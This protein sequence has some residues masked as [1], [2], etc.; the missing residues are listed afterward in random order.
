MY[1]SE[2]FDYKI[3]PDG[4]DTDEFYLKYKMLDLMF[5]G[6]EMRSNAAYLTDLIEKSYF[7]DGDLGNWESMV[8]GLADVIY[9]YSY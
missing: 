1:F 4:L 9:F 5:G 8:D 6:A 7:K 2:A 3:H